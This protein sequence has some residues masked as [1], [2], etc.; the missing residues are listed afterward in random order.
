MSECRTTIGRQA[1]KDK[2]TES[3]RDKTYLFPELV[4][5]LFNRPMEQEKLMNTLYHIAI[6]LNQNATKKRKRS[7][8]DVGQVSED[9]PV[10]GVAAKDTTREDDGSTDKVDAAADSLIVDGSIALRH[11]DRP[12]IIWLKNLSAYINDGAEILDSAIK[13]SSLSY[14][15]FM[16]DAR[17]HFD[18]EKEGLR[19]QVTEQGIKHTW[20]IDNEDE[21]GKA[22]R[23]GYNED[24]KG[25]LIHIVM[26]G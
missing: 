12:G 5:S 20:T 18:P 17:C 16:A 25:Y 15:K 19:M 24:K 14:E 3:I 26:T 11:Q 4:L 21:W 2:L 6:R 9:G 23:S 7:E 10:D 1:V 13:L 22:L 8:R